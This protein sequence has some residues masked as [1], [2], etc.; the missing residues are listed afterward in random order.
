MIAISYTHHARDTYD[1]S[2]AISRDRS[3]CSCYRIRE[4]GLCA[5]TTKIYVIRLATGCR[6]SIRHP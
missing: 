5:W 1:G 2:E 4:N 3:G 6:P